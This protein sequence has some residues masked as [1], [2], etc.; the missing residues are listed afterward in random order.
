MTR[1]DEYVTRR[2]NLALRYTSMLSHFPVTLPRSQELSTSAWHLYVIRLHADMLKRT[3]AEVFTSL[4]SCGIGVNVH[5]I[6]IHTQPFYR[7]MGFTPGDFPASKQYYSEA[8]SLPLFPT[9]TEDQ[10]DEVI[11]ALR[12]ECAGG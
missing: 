10:Q 9:L 4:R 1:L 6:P 5:Y 8:I 2:T 12:T 3:R 7:A 11:A